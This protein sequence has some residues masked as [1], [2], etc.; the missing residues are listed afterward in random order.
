[1]NDDGPDDTKT[2]ARVPCRRGGKRERVERDIDDV[3]RD[4]FLVHRGRRHDVAVLSL[5]RPE[6][7]ALERPRAWDL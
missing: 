2:G 3:G 7:E 1:M 6:W 5:L 4:D